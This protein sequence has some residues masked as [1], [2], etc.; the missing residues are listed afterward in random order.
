L[1]RADLGAV[2]PIVRP[3]SG[4][5]IAL[6]TSITVVGRA[7]IAASTTSGWTASRTARFLL[8]AT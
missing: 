4:T 5:P 7:A 8:A 2:V 6:D 3:S 1:S